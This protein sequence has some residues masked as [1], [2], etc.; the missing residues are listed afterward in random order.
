LLAELSLGQSLIFPAEVQ[1]Q[2]ST[3]TRL[4]AQLYLLRNV[5][6][7]ALRHEIMTRAINMVPAET[8][9]GDG[10]VLRK[11][12]RV[13]WLDNDVYPDIKALGKA[14][15]HILLSDQAKQSPG[16]GCEQLQVVHYYDE[17]GEFVLHHD[18]LTRVV[19]VLYYLNGVAGTWFPLANRN[20][21]PRNLED[22]L[23]LTEGCRPGRDGIVVVGKESPLLQ[24]CLPHHV[25]VVDPGDAVA[26]YNY[27]SIPQGQVADWNSLHAGLPTTQQEGS[28]WIANHW[29]HA[30]SLFQTIRPH[31]PVSS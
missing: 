31:Y 23:A 4:A 24:D 11:H 3:I 6:P 8:I 22:A 10:S 27:R 5:V 9:K 2:D 28:K 26:F 15:G 29:I 25:V 13:D 17:G 16:A 18:S 21:E 14:M 12:C 19:T 1:D 20:E 30:P 7:E